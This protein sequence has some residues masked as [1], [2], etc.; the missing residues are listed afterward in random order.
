MRTSPEKTAMTPRATTAGWLWMAR[1]G[2]PTLTWEGS[3]WAKMSVA[4]GRRLLVAQRHPSAAV[5]TIVR[6]DA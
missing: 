6:A 5:P 2:A 1:V 4:K 3:R